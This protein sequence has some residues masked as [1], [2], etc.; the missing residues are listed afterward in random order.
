MAMS[1]VSVVTN[2]QLLRRFRRPQSVNAI[3]RPRLRARVGQYAFLVTVAVIALAIGAGLTGLSR[4]DTARRGMNG[5]LA[6]TETTGMPMRPS[7][8]TMMTADIEPLDASDAGVD[9]QVHVPPNARPGVPTRIV[10]TVSDAVTGEPVDDLSLSHEVWM[11]LIATRADL[12]TFAH[13]HP[14]PTG[15]DGELAVT[16]TFPTAGLYILN[17]EVRRQG[18]MTDIHAR[19][20]VTIAGQAPAPVALAAGPRTQVIEGVRV[21]LH[22]DAVV[23]GASDLA[24]TFTDART[25]RALDDLRP[26]LAAAG[27]VVVMRGDAE[28]FAHEHADVED[29]GGDPV[30]AL[31]GQRY[32]P[33]LEFHAS[34]H[35]PG[36]YRLWGQ[37]RLANGDVLT[38]P[39]TVNAQ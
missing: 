23:G 27:H 15:R 1:S 6:W 12:G 16:L 39:F 20:A 19:Q 37:F 9:I 13:V 10:A 7:M 21:E 5:V 30:F 22:G 2:A 38:V 32:G 33:E 31:P 35:T 17:S 25:G 4:T 3:L 36:A 28:T 14:E 29:E 11:H 34:F 26:Y 18:Q 8:S 24:F